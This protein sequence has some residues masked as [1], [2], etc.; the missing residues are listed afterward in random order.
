MDPDSTNR[1]MDSTPITGQEPER[2]HVGRIRY[3][4]LFEFA[5]DCHV[6]TDSHGLIL[7]ANHAAASLLRCF[8]E[9]LIGKPLGLFVAPGFRN[10]FYQTL[11]LFRNRS[12]SDSFESRLAPRRGEGQR[13]VSIV[14][15]VDDDAD[16][17]HR[18]RNI[19]WAVR[20][21]TDQ[22]RAE[23]VRA[24]L[25][26]RL[27]TAQEDE[28]RRVSRDLHDQVGQTLMALVLGVQAARS[29]DALP[30]AAIEQLN[31]VQQIADDLGRQLREIAGRLRPTAL[32]DVGLEG[33]LRQSIADWSTQTGVEAEFRSTT[34]ESERFPSEIETTLYRVV[35]EALTNVAKH[36]RASH[37]GV[38][39]ARRD[40]YAVAVIE[41]DGCGF[42]PD[43][44]A[45][46]GNGQLGLIGMR[47]RVVLTGGTL[48]IESR[49]GH[50]TTIY[51]RIPCAGG[52]RGSDES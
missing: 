37:V 52:S 47:E 20:D 51:A 34:L 39:V 7:T 42:E 12:T 44:V 8:K 43:A 46:A 18:V 17:S 45:P 49:P 28:R 21:V 24:D 19:H 11:A 4:E 9:F 30:Q 27:T 29:G 36:A 22:R 31:R 26:R 16:G 38:V 13:D 3:Q 23:S 35:Q 1:N 6:V 32:D 40:C 50:G 10:R 2:P 33:A 48:E 15:V 25:L 5:S 14:A 41:D